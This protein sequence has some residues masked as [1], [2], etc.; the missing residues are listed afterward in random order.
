M[1]RFAAEISFGSGLIIRRVTDMGDWISSAEVNDTHEG[2]KLDE[3]DDGLLARVL[4]S[5]RRFF[6]SVGQG[7]IE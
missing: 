3:F 7:P 4:R 5:Q 1:F 6:T 2:A